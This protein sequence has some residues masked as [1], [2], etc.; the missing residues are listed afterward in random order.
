MNSQLRSSPAAFVLVI[1]FI[2]AGV[3]LRLDQL[4]SQLLLEDEWHAVYRVVHQS[5]AAIFL[6]FAHSDSSIPL[7]LL[8]VL[9]A[10][11]FGLSELGMRAPLVV[12]GVATLFLFPWYVARRVGVAEAL[13]FAALLAISPLLYFFSRTA[14]PY[15]LTLLL[16]WT[17]HVLFRRYYEASEP[18]G[19][20]AA[21]YAACAALASW[22]H[23]VIAPFVVGPFLPAVWQCA[24]AAG[25][26]RRRRATRLIV[27]A[28]A[29]ALPMAALLAPPLIAH[30]E[31]L[32][33]K[34]GVDLP[35]ADTLVGVWYLWFGT[36]TTAPVLLCGAFALLGIPALWRRLPEARSGAAGIALILLEIVVTRPAW[37]HNPPT[38]ARYLLPA[39]PLLLLATACGAVRVGH[40]LRNAMTRGIAPRLA[41]SLGSAAAALP[42]LTL[43]LT[44]PLPPLL[45]YPNGN[46]LHGAYGFDFRPEHNPVL[47]WMDGIPLSPWW[48]SLG[49]HPPGTLAI[50]VAP[51]PTESV[52]WDAPRWQR[53]SRQ[54]I[55]HGFLEPLCNDPRPNEVP[56]DERFRFRNAVH[57]GD[58]AE[59]AA[60]EVDFVVWQKPYRYH[61]HGLDVQV[62][63]DVAHCAPALQARFGLPAY[64]D[65]WLVVY[66]LPEARGKRD[67]AG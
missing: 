11:A 27:L 52:G 50:A 10:R 49:E 51:F 57:L 35:G 56:L 55:L 44:S 58:A 53:L 13:V 67:A 62:A 15:A 48:A 59:L 31:S 65:E 28:L 45:R 42:V 54:R 66:R 3:W 46:S 60:H 24:R 37:I 22:L 29:A 14:R 40:A 39:L 21:G 19:P 38:F 25:E 43:A 32:R 9:E 61:A 41:R 34:S 47:R 23:P 6:D 16:G 8:Y 5:P 33:L 30:P 1:A 36:G 7:T 17:A 63:A 26:E 2:G 18:R 4:A 12:A 64:E 20:D